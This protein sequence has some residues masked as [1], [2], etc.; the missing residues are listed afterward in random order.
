MARLSNFLEYAPPSGDYR[1]DK[2]LERLVQNVNDGRAS[3][4]AV[5]PALASSRTWPGFNGS[6]YP[7][8]Y[9]GRAANS[10]VAW[11]TQTTTPYLIWVCNS[12]NRVIVCDR[13]FDRWRIMPSAST[14]FAG[15]KEITIT[16]PVAICWVPYTGSGTTRGKFWVSSSGSDTITTIDPYNSFATATFTL[17]ASESN[18]T[19]LGYDSTNDRVWAITGGGTRICSLDPADGSNDAQSTGWTGLTCLAP[20]GASKLWLSKTSGLVTERLQYLLP[21]NISAAATNPGITVSAGVYSINYCSGV[22]QVF[23]INSAGDQRV[24][25]ADNVA[26]TGVELSTGY[27]H[28]GVPAA[29]IEETRTIVVGGQGTLIALD[30]Y[31]GAVTSL[32]YCES[33]RTS[34]SVHSARYISEYK[35][36]LIFSDAP[37]NLALWVCPSVL[38]LTE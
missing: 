8:L 25:F 5:T 35:E 22:N 32:G 15:I 26:D 17:G 20:A 37:T 9:S 7:L 27:N 14:P 16:S 10:W 36:V 28:W 4:A 23:W 24:G 21:S 29:W 12:S 18:V 1:F 3:T 33:F 19:W 38:E 31:T 11:E 30:A 34:G 6:N 13:V 2:W